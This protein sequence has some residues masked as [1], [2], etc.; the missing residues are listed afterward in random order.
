MPINNQVYLRIVLMT[1]NSFCHMPANLNEGSD[2][3]GW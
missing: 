1:Y 3:I 2:A